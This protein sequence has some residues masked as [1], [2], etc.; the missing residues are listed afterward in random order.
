MISQWKPYYLKAHWIWS[1][2]LFSPLYQDAISATN[3]RVIDDARAR[4][5]S[6]DLKRSTYYE[7]CS[8]YGL[9]VERVFQDGETPKCKG[10]ESSEAQILHW[11][12][13]CNV[14]RTV[15]SISIHPPQPLWPTW[16]FT[17]MNLHRLSQW[18]GQINRLHNYVKPSVGS[19]NKL[20]Y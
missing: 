7:T 5:L 15:I 8:T 13:P 20:E 3:P 2:I 6:N 9:N 11:R 16:N 12:N 14:L 10:V 4:K 19:S 17:I 1:R 18:C